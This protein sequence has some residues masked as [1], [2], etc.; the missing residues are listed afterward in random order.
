MQNYNNNKKSCKNVQTKYLTQTHLFLPFDRCYMILPGGL[1]FNHMFKLLIIFIVKGANSVKI[2][3]RD[4]RF[5][6]CLF[7]VASLVTLNKQM[8]SSLETY[9]AF[10]LVNHKAQ[11]NLVWVHMVDI[12]T[13]LKNSW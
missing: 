11:L 5:I 12:C 7:K 1:H 9:D 13:A 8:L 3:Q 6:H 4:I 2:F 10:S